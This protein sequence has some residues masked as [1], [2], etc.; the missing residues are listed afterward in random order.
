VKTI[1]SEFFKKDDSFPKTPFPSLE[2]LVF[3]YMPKLQRELPTYLPALEE[4]E[5]ERC[6]QLASSLAT[7][8]GIHKIHICGSNKVFLQE[9]Q[10]SLGHLSSCCDMELNTHKGKS[11]L[12]V[13]NSVHNNKYLII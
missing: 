6:N 4:I 9:L 3:M 2:Y 12:E 10:T 1:G 5:I 7:A 11:K 13:I 8:P